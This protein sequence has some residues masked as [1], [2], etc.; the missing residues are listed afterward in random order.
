MKRIFTLAI[1][2]GLGHGFSYSQCVE[3]TEK[4]VLLVGDSWAAFMNADAV[5]N[6]G[7]RNMGHSDIKFVSNVVIAENG[8]ETD[9]FLTQTK[10]DAIQAL[11]DANPSVDIVHLSIGGNDVMGDWNINY[12]QQE[13]DSLEAAVAGRLNQVVDFLEGTREGM[14]VFWAGYCYPNFEEVIEEVAPF[15]TTHPFYGTWND[16]GQPTFLQI[17]TILNNFSDSVAA[18]ADADPQMDFVRAQGI[19][20]HVYGQT[21]PLGVA[22]G[23]TYQPFDAP[24]PLGFPEYPS[25]KSTMRLYA[26]IFTDCF[27]L[28]QE[29]YIT[30]FEYQ[31]LKFY[32]KF[33]M[34]DLYLLSEGGNTDGSVT[35][36]GEVSNVIKI[37]E[38][39]GNEVAA[40]LTF[41]TQSMADTTLSGAS[42]FLRR[43]SLTGTS[44]FA[45]TEVNVKMKSGS[46]G[47][48]ADVEA[49]DYTESGDAEGTPCRYGSHAKDGHWV[50][51]DLTAEMIA[52]INNGAQTQFV[53]S[54]PGFTGGVMTFSD[55]TDDELAPVLNLKYGPQ[56]DGIGEI[57]RARELPVYPIPTTGPL[58]IDV[59]V[60]ALVTVDVLNVL[61]ETVLQP[62]PSNNRIDISELR[63]GSYI[64]RITTKDGISAKRIIK[65]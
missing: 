2:L 16:M 7:L 29:A 12:T 38:E 55:A 48:S 34:D 59:D 10:Q 51:L 43:E 36:A 9:D 53:I 11:V 1:M 26:G 52:N 8:A 37:G 13:T 21:Q 6:D 31:T 27:H 18:Y 46:F 50:R 41:D 25:P 62:T 33:L 32:H 15:Q 60:N 3:Q 24:L 39:A 17:N 5:I 19:L 63:P 49:V 58:T 20:Q 4:R 45:G 22:P 40:V 44:P 57:A 30:M 61:G 47:T 64:L 42:I 23:G 54:I 35:S 56:P 65:R 14:R 28:S